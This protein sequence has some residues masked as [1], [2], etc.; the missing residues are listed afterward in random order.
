MTRPR[1]LRTTP[2]LRALVSETRLHARDLVLP[3]F[4]KE[5][6]TQPVGISSMPGVVHH[7]E[8]SLAAAVREAAEAGIGGVMLF[9]VPITR[10]ATGS[11]ADD[12]D[13][14][15]NV[16]IRIAVEA[17]AG[18]LVVMADLCLDE[19]TDHGHCG[20]LDSRGGV[21]NDATLRRYEAMAIAQAQAGAEV[22][23]LSGMMDG[24]VFAVRS[25]LDS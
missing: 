21:D 11:G 16:G 1:R 8:E 5:G 18:R 7:S 15:L 4:I 19:F 14:I 20:V 10:D 3:L 13:G 12:P 6:A 25:A 23:G 17:A 9:G 22:L 2:A 24:Q